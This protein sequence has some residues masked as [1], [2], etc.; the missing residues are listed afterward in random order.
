MG[1]V[2]SDDVTSTCSDWTLIISGVTGENNM[3]MLSP[4]LSILALCH[5]L[6][7][8]SVA[9]NSVA[10]KGCQIQTFHFKVLFR[11]TGTLLA[12]VVATHLFMIILRGMLW[13]SACSTRQVTLDGNLLVHPSTVKTELLGTQTGFSFKPIVTCPMA[14][15]FPLTFHWSFFLDRS[16]VFGDLVCCTKCSVLSYVWIEEDTQLGK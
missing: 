11:M 13:C 2:M 15:S 6:S 8:W 4:F 10:T 3:L 14:L 12:F 7:I 16:S 5:I 1:Q 9:N